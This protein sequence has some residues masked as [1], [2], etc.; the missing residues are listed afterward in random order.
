MVIP[1]LSSPL[2]NLANKQSHHYRNTLDLQITH[3]LLLKKHLT[4]I[5][6]ISANRFPIA[7]VD[8]DE[9]M[10]S[11]VINELN[12]DNKSSKPP[13]IIIQD[14]INY[15]KLNVK[16]IELTDTTSFDC[17][18]STK[19]L[20]LQTYNPESYRTVLNT[21]RSIMSHFTHFN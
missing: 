12:N 7:R 20:K 8:V 18:I 2:T 13:P 3:L 5:I 21:S 1:S 4:K 6:F 19:R 11:T 9:P 16:I 14:Q 10:D 15:N 17:K